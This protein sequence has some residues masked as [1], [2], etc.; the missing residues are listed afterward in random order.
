MKTIKTISPPD[1]FNR[2]HTYYKA[3]P[4]SPDGSRVLCFRFTNL[5]NPGHICLLDLESN[6]E[7][8]LA[9]AE[10][11]DYHSGANAYFC[12]QGNKIIFREKENV[13]GIYDIY[14]EKLSR[15]SGTHSNYC[16]NIDKTYIEV[17][18]GFPLERQGKMGIY[19]CSIN[20]SEKRLLVTVND[21]LAAHPLGK[22]LK[23]AEIL[24]RLGAEISPDQQKVRLGLLTRCGGL[25]KDFYT[26]NLE[27]DLNLQF[28]GK[29]GSH[30][31]WH[32]D[33]SSILTVVNSCSDG[34]VRLKEISGFI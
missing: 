9:E 11:A 34:V 13:I 14:T 20:G 6:K 22:A 28:H 7:K 30:P 27:G 2:I 5:Q 32:S 26:C 15:L 8:V 25:V 18:S 24:F 31:G 17:D 23:N 10:T 33:S 21:L 19:A 1:S 3:S 12:D 16:G 29:L 4:Y